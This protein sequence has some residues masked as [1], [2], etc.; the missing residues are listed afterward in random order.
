MVKLSLGSECNSCICYKLFENREEEKDL[1]TLIVQNAQTLKVLDL[2]CYLKLNTE[3]IQHILCSCKNLTEID[4]SKSKLRTKSISALVNFVPSDLLKLNLSGLRINDRNLEKLVKRCNKIIELDLSST[5]ITLKGV[6]LIS[7]NLSNSLVNLSLPNEIGLCLYSSPDLC[8]IIFLIASLKHLW[9]K[10]CDVYEL[11]R[12]SEDHSRSSEALEFEIIHL[13][14]MLQHL[15]INKIPHNIADPSYPYGDNGIW[16]I[17]CEQ[18]DFFP[19]YEF[20]L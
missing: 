3:D 17:K 1:A 7:D 20:Q 19:S 15:T 2:S 9:W 11:K 16:E 5:L 12:R 14:Q 10:S 18:D 6:I 4:F 13:K 8:E